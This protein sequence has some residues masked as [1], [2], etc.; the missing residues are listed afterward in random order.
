[1]SDS[2]A[3]QV[4]GMT[5]AWGSMSHVGAV[6]DHNEDALLAD[7]S[8]FLVAD[9]LGGHAAGEVASALAVATVAEELAGVEA[10][11][12][13]AV[14]AAVQKAAVAVY[15]AAAGDEALTGMGT[16]VTGLALSA[17]ADDLAW[18]VLNVG[19][20]RVYLLADGTLEQLTRDHSEVQ[21]LLDAGL[22]DEEEAAQHPF[23]NVITRHVGGPWPP[24]VDLWRRPVRAGERYLLCSDGVSNELPG[25][26]LRELLQEPGPPAQAAQRVV[27]A[28]VRAG[29]RDNAT[30]VVV[31]VTG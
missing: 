19:D 1:M 4:G 31:D 5:V 22:I 9:G 16:T 3:R 23:R 26:R 28:A 18:I 29:G 21:Q 10:V 2:A 12:E 24:D 8:L 15:E 25:D 14:S 6:R 27:E 17:A 13:E 7:G 30:V 20:S 11:D